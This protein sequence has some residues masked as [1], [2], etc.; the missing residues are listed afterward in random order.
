L[1]NAML[2]NSEPAVPF[3]PNGQPAATSSKHMVLQCDGAESICDM[4]EARSSVKAAAEEEMQME[5]AAEGDAE[6]VAGEADVVLLVEGWFNAHFKRLQIEQL[7]NDDRESD[8]E[9]VYE[10]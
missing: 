2:Q 1:R 4:A 10:M 3:A 6:R 9:S 7:A 8:A 5:D